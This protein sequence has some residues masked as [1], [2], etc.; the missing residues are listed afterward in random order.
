MSQLSHDEY[1]QVRKKE[2]ELL[3]TYLEDMS[4]EALEKYEKQMFNLTLLK[5]KGSTCLG[6][7]LDRSLPH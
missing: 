7:I 6:C 5:V 1:Q 2:S 4:P 3:K